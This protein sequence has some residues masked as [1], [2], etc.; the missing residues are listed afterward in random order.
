MGE[1]PMKRSEIRSA[2]KAVTHNWDIPQAVRNMVLADAIKTVQ[3]H[4]SSIRQRQ[5]ASRLIVAM[6][7]QN[8]D[9]EKAK[10]PQ[11]GLNVNVDAPDPG[12]ARRIARELL[13][14]P[15]YLAYQRSRLTSSDARD[16]CGECEQG[17]SGTVDASESPAAD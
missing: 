11:I 8:I 5:S 12:E 17:T 15:E 13:N 9:L 14:D 6:N 3:H 7:A 10:N 2:I 4:E 1:V 16:V